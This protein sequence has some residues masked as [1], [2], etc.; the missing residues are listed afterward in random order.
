MTGVN[1]VFYFE[2]NVKFITVRYGGIWYGTGMTL[3]KY[4]IVYDL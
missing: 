4:E 2:A 3:L 1:I